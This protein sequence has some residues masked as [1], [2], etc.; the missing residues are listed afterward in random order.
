MGMG[1][2]LESSGEADRGFEIPAGVDSEVGTDVGDAI[3]LGVTDPEHPTSARMAAIPKKSEGTRPEMLL[4][5][6]DLFQFISTRSCGPKPNPFGVLSV[7]QVVMLQRIPVLE[8]S[9][10]GSRLQLS[11]FTEFR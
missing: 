5:P 10:K 4:S 8:R 1:P 7:S 11:C 6:A 3:G 2:F 9:N